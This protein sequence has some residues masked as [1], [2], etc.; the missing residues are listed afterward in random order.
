V[1]V[2]NP[3]LIE[4]AFAQSQPDVVVHA[5]ALTHVDICET[6][7]P[8]A[9]AINVEGTRHVALQAHKYKAFLI[10]ISTDYIF[11]GTQGNYTERDDPNPINY[12][13]QSK[14][15]GERIIQHMLDDWCIARPSVIFGALPAA[16]KINFALWII[17]KLQN[18]EEINIV[19][20]QIISP[21][22]NANLSTM[23]LEIA[24][25]RLSGIYHLA[26]ATSINRYDF[27]IQLA[28]QFNLNRG[29]IK[30][31]LSTDM[32]WIAPRPQDTSLNVEKA[33]QHLVNKPITLSE[34][35]TELFE[36]R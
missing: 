20:D 2:Q 19:T 21:T 8:L 33:T 7:K 25:R 29:L 1:D 26:G 12:Y 32:K 11:S 18:K 31:A 10:Y 27:T 22:Y 5:S 30:P 23:I 3:T 34:A 17:E 28:K 13:G 6:N 35:F 9:R 15:E 16:G 4:K 14:L 36:A 24:Q